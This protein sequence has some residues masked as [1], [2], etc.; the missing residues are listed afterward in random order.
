MLLALARSGLQPLRLG[1][2]TLLPV[3]QGGMVA[4]GPAA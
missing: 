3:V 2:H 1:G 4:G